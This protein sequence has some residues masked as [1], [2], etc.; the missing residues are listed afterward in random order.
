[1]TSGRTADDELRE[2]LVEAADDLFYARGIQA[3][4]M[5]AVREAAGVSLKKI[6]ALVG[7]KDELVVA[8]LRRRARALQEALEASADRAGDA[9]AKVLSVFDFLDAWFCE[10]GFRGCGFI[11]AFGELGSTTPAVA[12]AVRRQKAA[13]REFVTELVVA[14]GGTP[15]AAVQIALLAEGAQTTAAISGDPHVAREA[16]A[17]AATLLDAATPATV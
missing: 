9:R 2:R 12:D 3:V 10:P 7:S 5:D 15:Q 14:A 13:F 1:M 4:G 6:Y 11:N 8:V 17:A 16:G